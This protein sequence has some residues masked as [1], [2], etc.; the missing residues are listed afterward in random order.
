MADPLSFT[1]SLIAVGTLAVQVSQLVKHALHASDEALALEDELEDLKALS[2]QLE[3]LCREQWPKEHQTNVDEAERILEDSI[4]KRLRNLQALFVRHCS[5]SKLRSVSWVVLRRKIHSERTALHIGKERL[6]NIFHL[7][8]TSTTRSLSFQPTQLNIDLEHIRSS[9]DRNFQDI[10]TRLGRCSDPMSSLQSLRQLVERLQLGVDE[11]N[12]KLTK[13]TDEM[14]KQLLG[15]RT[16]PAVLDAKSSFITPHPHRPSTY[17]LIGCIVEGRESKCALWCSCACHSSSKHVSLP[18]SLER[19]TGQ[20]LIGFS[21]HPWLRPGCNLQGCKRSSETRVQLRYRFPAWWFLRYSISLLAQTKDLGLTLRF[22]QVRPCDADVFEMVAHWR[23]DAIK[24]AFTFKT[25]SIYDVEDTG[26]HTLL[27]RALLTRNVDMIEFLLRQ[28]ADMLAVNQKKNSSADIFWRTILSNGLPAAAYHRLASYF[29]DTTFIDDGGFTIIHKIIFGQSKANLDHLLT[30]M[31][32]LVDQQDNY[33]LTP[34]HWAATRGDV[35]S[36]A[37]LLKH[38]ANVN[39]T[40]RGGSTPLI[41]GID[42][43]NPE[44]TRRLLLAGADPNHTSKIWLDRAIHIACNQERFHCQI[45]V[46]L[47]FGA[48]ASASSRLR[49]SPLKFAASQDFAVSVEVLIKATDPSKHTKAVIAAVKNDALQALQ[50]LM[51]LGADCTGVDAEG[52]TVLHHAAARGSDPTL[53]LLALYKHMLPHQTEDQSGRLP[54]EYARERSHGQL[55]REVLKSLFNV[56][57]EEAIGVEKVFIQRVSN[58][59]ESELSDE[60]N[61]TFEDALQHPMAG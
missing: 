22:P 42:S 57:D 54:V 9:Q 27:H 55:S 34:L 14:R 13:G 17:P 1:A 2:K 24:T 38:N 35:E 61:I 8:N 49:D 5:R 60:E 25:A 39:I 48:D 21:V 7:I 47:E 26:G 15:P 23:L 19:I 11:I 45:P 18:N 12:L 46:L 31:P 4:Q 53:R 51:E 6:L 32:N 36:I 29:T 56:E 50:K 59:D 20:L 30:D 37:T 10:V 40:E 28:G 3:T 52:K 58:A 43:A 41:W 33:G 44:V 16:P